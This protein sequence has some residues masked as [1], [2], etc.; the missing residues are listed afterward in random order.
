MQPRNPKSP[1]SLGKVLSPKM[2]FTLNH[3][4]ALNGKLLDQLGDASL[5]K[6]ANKVASLCPVGVALKVEPLR[7]TYAP[8]IRT[9]HELQ[10][11][12]PRGILP[13]AHVTP[14]NTCTRVHEWGAR[15]MRIA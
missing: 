15:I 2:L 9:G 3:P 11:L 12:S 6:G 4:I 5:G 14:N 13:L 10:S 7:D 1:L 8:S